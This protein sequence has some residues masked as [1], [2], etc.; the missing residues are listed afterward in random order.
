MYMYAHIN[1]YVCIH[2]Y[3]CVYTCTYRYIC[4]F[5]Y[6]HINSYMY[7]YTDVDAHMQDASPPLLEAVCQHKD[8]HHHSHTPKWEK[9]KSKHKP[10]C[11]DKFI[12]NFSQS[13]SLSCTARSRAVLYFSQKA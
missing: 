2:A 1:I 12:Q 4:I 10:V 11:S 8:K 13:V 3:T 5:I 7:S 9:K 6:M